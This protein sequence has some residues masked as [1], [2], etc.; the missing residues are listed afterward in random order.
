MAGTNREELTKKLVCAHR[1]VL[2]YSLVT[3]LQKDA[4]KSLEMPDTFFAST[5]RHMFYEFSSATTATTATTLYCKDCAQVV[6]YAV[7]DPRPLWQAHGDGQIELPD[8]IS[9]T[10]FRGVARAA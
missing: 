8:G 9:V 4:W 5:E 3:K 7:D 6:F 1:Q 10:V 2:H